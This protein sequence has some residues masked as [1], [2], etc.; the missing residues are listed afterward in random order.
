MATAKTETERKTIPVILDLGNFSLKCIRD[1]LTGNDKEIKIPSLL[2]DVTHR[3]QIE[4]SELTPVVGIGDRSIH[5]GE[6]DYGNDAL[7]VVTH[8]KSDSSIFLPCIYAV[9]PW[10]YSGKYDVD[11]TI[12]F[13]PAL[14]G[15]YADKLSE[16]KRVHHFTKNGRDYE[17]RL[18]EVRVKFEGL[19]AFYVAQSNGQISPKA[20]LIIDVGGKTVNGLVWAKGKPIDRITFATGGGYDIARMITSDTRLQDRYGSTFSNIYS[21]MNAIANGSF[22]LDSQNTGEYV[23]FEDIYRDVLETWYKRLKGDVSARL[24]GRT[25]ID[26]ILFTGGNAQNL[27]TYSCIKNPSI[28]VEGADMANVRGLFQDF[29]DNQK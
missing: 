25:G 13:P 3:I 11:L 27:L 10:K 23:D 20:T 21:V 8:N 2:T 1:G 15:S 26:R 19:G 29:K 4:P 16:L 18:K 7:S 14:A 5:L 24:S 6:S 12:S 17:V 22:L 9:M 28:I